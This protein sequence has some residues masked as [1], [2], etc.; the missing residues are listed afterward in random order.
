MNEAVRNP[1]GKAPVVLVVLVETARLRWFLAALSLD[2]SLTPLVRSDEGDLA[3]YQGLGFD[4]QVSFLR[5]RFCGILQRGCDRLWPV[6]KKACQFVFL[7]DGLLPN[8]SEE[9]L[10][11]VADHF[12][13][14]MLNPPVVVF[15]NRSDPGAG[16]DSLHQL[17]G[18]INPPLAQVLF[19]TLPSLLTAARD[20]QFWELS[21]R[22]GT[23]QPSS[24]N[25]T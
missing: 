24:R 5:H 21:R 22:Q 19:A 7:F 17:A 9:L 18:A 4:D 3:P 6:G 14:W 20:T 1:S 23:W 12:A 10:Q 2:G 16:H 11:R 25:D 15:L 8:T 13:E